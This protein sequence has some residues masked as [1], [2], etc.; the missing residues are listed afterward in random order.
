MASRSI[1]DPFRGH[2]PRDSE[3]A[4]GPTSFVPSWES[5]SFPLAA[6]DVAD[7]GSP[8][9]LTVGAVMTRDPRFCRPDDTLAAAAVAMC[10]A[11]C[12]FLPVVDRGGVP[13]GVLTDG[14]VCLLGATDHRRLR[15]IFVRE[16]MNGF[17]ATCRSDDRLEDALA[18]MRRRHIRHLPVVDRGGALEGVVSLTDV[19][20]GAEEA[21]SPALRLD[22]AQTLRDIVQKQGNRR[23][24]LRNSFITD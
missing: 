3:R 15:D 20:L 12:R 23:T 16:W 9:L 13:V 21:D 19:V 18:L 11:D 4:K 14:D 1:D 17:P 24:I 2:D 7:P 5:E 10:E 6:K 8:S 22:V